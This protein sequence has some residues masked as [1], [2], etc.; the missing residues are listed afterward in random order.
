MVTSS[1]HREKA[2]SAPR[3]RA[4]AALAHAAGEGAIAL[5][6][7]RGVIDQKAAGARPSKPKPAVIASSNGKAA[8]PEPACGSG[9]AVKGLLRRPGPA[10]HRRIA[11]GG[12]RSSAA[13]AAAPAAPP[14]IRIAPTSASQTLSPPPRRPR[15]D[16]AHQI[17]R[18]Q[19]ARSESPHQR[20]DVL[21]R[22]G[23]FQFGQGPERQA[24]TRSRPSIIG[25]TS[26]PAGSRHRQA[27]A[28]V[29]RPADSSETSKVTSP[30]CSRHFERRD[31]EGTS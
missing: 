7:S 28:K 10:P 31:L 8:A 17:A 16:D 22:E 23:V 15:P 24:Q 20:R 14:S 3:D 30:L 2:P 12:G 9:A 13:M 1:V 26:P 11:E 27:T 29:R 6:N 4:A 25:P 18:A 21:R 5:A 19:A